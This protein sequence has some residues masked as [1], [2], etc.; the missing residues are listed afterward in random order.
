LAREGAADLDAV[1]TLQVTS[2]IGGEPAGSGG[3][4]GAKEN[5]GALRIPREAPAIF[6]GDC[7]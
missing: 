7:R 6:T 4:S 5:C 2:R 1:N 3:G